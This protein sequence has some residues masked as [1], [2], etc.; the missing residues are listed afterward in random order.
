MEEDEQR[1]LLG[2]RGAVEA[3]GDRAGLQLLHPRQL[4]TARALRGAGGRALAHRRGAGGV[5][6]GGVLGHR[7]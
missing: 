6:L 1:A 4:G 2:G 7:P 5:G 3:R